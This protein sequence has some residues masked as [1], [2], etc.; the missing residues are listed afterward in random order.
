MHVCFPNVPLFS[1]SLRL[2]VTVYYLDVKASSSQ[3]LSVSTD[4]K[5]NNHVI[6]PR[7]VVQRHLLML[8]KHE[9]G[10]AFT[11]HGMVQVQQT[12]KGAM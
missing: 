5:P 8:Y 3:A 2:M 4:R 10:V 6:R 11:L 12:C 9:Q 7:L 1:P